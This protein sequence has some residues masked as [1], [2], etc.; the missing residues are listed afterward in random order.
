MVNNPLVTVIIVS[1]NHSGYIKECLDSIKNQTYENIQLI[2]GDDASPDNSV[3]VFENWINDNKYTAEKNFHSKNT[4]LAEMLNEC[5]KFAKGKYIKLIAADDY[6]HPEF[7]EKCVKTLENKDDKFAVVFSSAYIV[8]EDKNLVEYYGNFDF[9]RDEYQFRKLE[10]TR[11]FVPAVSALIKTKALLETGSYNK[12]ILLEDYDK[13]LQIN[14]KH[15]FAFIPE[16]LAY[17]RKHEENI[18]TLK[19]RV[20]FV[21][22]I[23]LRLQYDTELDNKS[24]L[25]NSVKKIYITSTN[26]KELKKTFE[27]YN[28]YKG[29]EP[30]LNFCLKYRLPIKLYHLK[31]KFF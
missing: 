11:N 1:Y 27:K 25:N 17:Y 15:F 3:E 29:K 30:W 19:A 24:E 8:E 12:D 22:E 2:V 26:K 13:W 20:V 23:L 18:S 21:E 6:L 5:I 14:E 31:Y 10:K 28:Q 16:H 9:Y 7:L 4:G